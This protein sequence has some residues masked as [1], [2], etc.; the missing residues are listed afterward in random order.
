MINKVILLGNVG[1]DPEIRHLENR[2][3]V[4]NFTL[5]TSERYRDNS[6]LMQERTEWHTIVCW[7]PTADVVEKY[8]RK[9]TQLYI[10]GKI[11][12]RSYDAK[13]GGKRYVTEIFVDNLQLLGRKGDNPANQSSEGGYSKP[14]IANTP[15]TQ[16]AP[17]VSNASD[18]ANNQPF[19]NQ[20]YPDMIDM[21]GTETDDLPF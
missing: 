20:D 14:S 5:A 2:R 11:R 7:G 15:T 3:S 10:E 21:G 12:T 6:G 9:G 19:G 8:V 4:A 1:R 17:S 13:D 16:S 18:I